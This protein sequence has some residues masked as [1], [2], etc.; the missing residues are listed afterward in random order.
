MLD[1]KTSKL[2]GISDHVIRGRNKITKKDNEKIRKQI[3][4]WV[5]FYFI[6]VF[7]YNLIAILLS[8][9][10]LFGIKGYTILIGFSLI[11]Y[12]IKTGREDV[13][14]YIANIENTD[15]SLLEE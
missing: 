1:T 13:S 7:H 15:E 8:W 14:N 3:K 2:L 10:L 9:L 12:W 4:F 6:E 11:V 5:S